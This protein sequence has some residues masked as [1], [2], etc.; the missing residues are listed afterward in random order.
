MV[1]IGQKM[2]NVVFEWPLTI[3]NIDDFFI[4]SKN[5]AI[6]FY[7]WGHSK[8]TLTIFCP[9]LTTYLP[10]VDMFTKQAC[11]VNV[12]FECPLNAEMEIR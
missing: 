10:L 9:I 7:I 4:P 1:E 5:F 11:L 2:V 6:I 3:S 8:T 12:V